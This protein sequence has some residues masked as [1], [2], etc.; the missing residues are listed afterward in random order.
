MSCPI[1]W[2]LSPPPPSL[3]R[4]LRGSG[5]S[6]GDGRGFLGQSQTVTTLCP[7]VPGC[8][9]DRSVPKASPSLLQLPLRRIPR[10]P[11]QARQELKNPEP[12]FPPLFQTSALGLGFIFIIIICLNSG[13]GRSFG[14]RLGLFVFYLPGAAALY[15][16]PQ[17]LALSALERKS[18]L[19]PYFHIFLWIELG[20]GGYLKVR[21]LAEVTA[22][23]RPWEQG[24]AVLWELIPWCF[25]FPALPHHQTLYFL[26]FSGKK[27]T[28]KL[29]GV[30]LWMCHCQAGVGKAT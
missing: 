28:S 29:P 2:E 19:F 4:D 30:D 10:A 13:I 6:T 26:V 11:S 1:P 22:L 12:H 18:F 23:A 20:W 9:G 24:A 8:G 7:L 27:S 17:H 3:L 14:V 5:P 25:I 16:L 21:G 15:W